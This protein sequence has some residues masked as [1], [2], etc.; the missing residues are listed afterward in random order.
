MARVLNAL[1]Q[2]GGPSRNG[3]FRHVQVRRGNRLIATVDLYEYL[4]TGGSGSDVRLENGDRDTIQ[5]YSYGARFR[6]TLAGQIDFAGIDA[7]LKYKIMTA[8]IIPRPPALVS[9]EMLALTTL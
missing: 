2:A 4:L 7:K 6:R 9:P 3:S 1:Y 5:L 8:A